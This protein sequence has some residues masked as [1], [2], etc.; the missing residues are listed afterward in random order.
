MRRQASQAF[1]KQQGI[2]LV[3]VLWV[4]AL[5]GA[6]AAVYSAGVRN[7][8]TITRNMV[9]S[10]K[11]RALVDAGFHI[12]EMKFCENAPA[13]AENEAW[14]A[15]GTVYETAFGEGT[16]RVAVVD[17]AG[18]IDLN[19]AP[20]EV[21]DVLL[22]NAEVPDQ[23]R[24]ALVD[25][26]LDW[27]DVDNLRGLYGAEDEEYADAGL[28]YGAKDAPFES[29]E[30]LLLVLGMKPAWYQAI[31]SAVTV[32]SGSDSINPVVASEQVLKA[33]PGVDGTRVDEYVQQRQQHS[34]ESRPFSQSVFGANPYLII[35]AGHTF[36]LNIEGETSSGAIARTTA[37][38]QTRRGRNKSRFQVLV[39][40]EPGI[41][42]T[43]LN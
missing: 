28:P 34:T 10:A 5:L 4:L 24:M 11:A 21:I 16:V 37:I 43:K 40:E 7:E 8:T 14:Q 15:D 42:L 35:N 17:E 12:A 36:T 18:K 26:I 13:T 25:A 31:A 22:L 2:A 9:E 30:E 20:K 19:E 29:K 33:M 27:R 6:I 3:V 39:W 38:V 1:G 32:Y 41:W 23:E